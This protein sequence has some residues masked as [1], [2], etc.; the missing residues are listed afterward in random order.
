MAGLTWLNERDENEPMCFLFF[1]SFFSFF[2]RILAGSTMSTS[3]PVATEEGKY[4]DFFESRSVAC[5]HVTML[6]VLLQQIPGKTWN[7]DRS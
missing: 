6:P 3:L 7:S 5:S 1:S 2:H 4:G